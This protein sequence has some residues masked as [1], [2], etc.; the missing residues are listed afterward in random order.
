MV[1]MQTGLN[2]VL[3]RFPL[4]SDIPGRP[5]QGGASGTSHHYQSPRTQNGVH[6][7]SVVPAASITND[8]ALRLSAQD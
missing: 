3:V 4:D 1:A 7:S 2:Y 8:A 6:H 5:I